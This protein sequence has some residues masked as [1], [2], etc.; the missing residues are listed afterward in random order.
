MKRHGRQYRAFTL[1]ELLVVI[2][3]I[4]LLI[5]I[6]LPALGR[7]RDQAN[8]VACQAN[9]RSF[10]TLWVQ[11]ANENKGKVVQA[12]YQKHDATTNAEFG[13]YDG[14]F[15]GTVLKANN[16]AYSSQDRGRDIAKVIKYLL[17]C[18]SVDHS[19]DPNPEELSATAQY[20]GFYFGDYVYNTWM[21]SRKTVSG[22][23]TDEEDTA[24]SLPNLKL[25]QIPGNV[26][27]LMESRKPNIT[28]SGAT[29]APVALPGG[30]YKSYFQKFNEIFEQSM[31]SGQPSRSLTL[32]RIGTPHQKNKKMNV[33]SADGHISTVDPYTDFFTN[34]NDQSTVKQY[35]W[36]AKDKLRTGWKKGAPG[37]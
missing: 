21:G 29:W 25:N 5:S 14:A 28:G 17:Q 24:G 9:L 30:G 2:G 26:I 13:F 20:T 6:L 34:P 32:L 3:I 7:A 18:R 8:M 23:T 36:D 11:Y 22:T 33:L 10:Y 35:L 27:I 4:A 37:I 1:V 19:S 12:R 16:S 15:M 31:T